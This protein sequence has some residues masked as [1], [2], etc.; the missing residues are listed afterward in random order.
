MPHDAAHERPTVYAHT[1]AHGLQVVWHQ[2]LLRRCHHGLG[3]AKDVIGVRAIVVL[4]HAAEAILVLLNQPPRHHC[5]F[6]QVQAGFRAFRQAGH[7]QGSGRQG[8]VRGVWV[9]G[10]QAGYRQAGFSEGGLGQWGSG[11]V[12]AVRTEIVQCVLCT[13]W[14]EGVYCVLCTVWT[15]V[16]MCTDGVLYTV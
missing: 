9:S 4:N 11:R 1:Q 8:S 6:V 14:T 3:K 13:V 12:C 15:E 5:G 7:R 10:V 2:H 16:L